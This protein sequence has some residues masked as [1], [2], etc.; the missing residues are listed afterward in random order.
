[1]NSV[2]STKVLFIALSILPFTL[3]SCSMFQQCHSGGCD[4]IP[5]EGEKKNTRIL[6]HTGEI[7]CPDFE[8]KEACCDYEQVREIK[9]NFITL[10]SIFGSSAGGCDVCSLNLKR[11]YCQFTC[12]PKQDTFLFPTGFKN[13]TV[14]G[15]VT[16][17]L[18][19]VDLHINE[20]TACEVF[21]SCKKSKF[22]AQVPSMNN[23]LGFLNFQ[24]VNAYKKSAIYMNMILDKEGGM[25][26]EI[27]PCETE[28]I[29][30]K[31]RNMTIEQNCTCNTC[32]AKC[33]FSAVSKTPVLDGLNVTLVAVFYLCV[34]AL[35]VVIYFLKKYCASP[36]K[37]DYL[38]NEN[39]SKDNTLFGHDVINK[40][41]ASGAM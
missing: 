35:T 7:I 17:L 8:G 27:D 20:D 39:P 18:L 12:D 29:D 25:K 40:T 31:L 13:H 6:Y 5:A 38:L 37:D 26:Y 34:I 19:D 21:K 24:G 33:D 9:A 4:P 22:V 28:A 15:N 30:G 36:D 14:D 2:L 23:A 41:N 10:D 3:N 16:K 1:M 32:S 11:F